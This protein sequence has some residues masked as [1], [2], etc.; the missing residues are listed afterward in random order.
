MILTIISGINVSVKLE[1]KFNNKQYFNMQPELVD[2]GLYSSLA[3]TK[4]QLRS[5]VKSMYS[6]PY[7][8]ATVEVTL[9][10]V[11]DNCNLF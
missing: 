3:L 2:W 6:T 9:Q 7:R 1:V 4:G 8:G 11:G 5:A 10:N